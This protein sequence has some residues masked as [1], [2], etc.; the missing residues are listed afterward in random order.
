[1]IT[2][3]AAAPDTAITRALG[4]MIGQRVW[5]GLPVVRGMVDRVPPPR[6]RQYAVVTPL[7]AQPAGTTLHGYARPA[8][9]AD[10]GAQEVRQRLIRRVQ[11][12]FYGANADAMCATFAALA[13]DARGVDFCA[14]YGVTP[15]YTGAAQAMPEPDGRENWTNRWTV[16]VFVQFDAAVTLEQE[17][18]ATVKLTTRLANPAAQEA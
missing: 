1:M 14:P 3:N 11:V 10:M 15:L 9:V 12:D 2:V 16:D 8:N 13:N 6:G 17:Y 7:T 5:P 18:F 4:D